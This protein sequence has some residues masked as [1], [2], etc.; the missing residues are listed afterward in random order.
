MISNND[1]FYSEV[2]RY[3]NSK[4]VSYDILLYIMNSECISLVKQLRTF[5]KYAVKKNKCYYT[6][7]I[8]LC[9]LQNNID[10]IIC[11]LEIDSNITIPAA[12]LIRIFQTINS[13]N[14]LATALQRDK[15]IFFHLMYYFPECKF[16]LQTY[17]M[18]LVDLYSYD[19]FEEIIYRGLPRDPLLYD[20]AIQYS[21]KDAIK[22]LLMNEYPYDIQSML[23]TALYY[24]LLDMIKFIF[25]KFSEHK[26]MMKPL[27]INSRLYREVLF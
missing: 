9:Q 6:K 10:R 15:R 4:Y 22:L 20:D 7:I 24:D 18:I 21:N 11:L 26:D 8:H 12:D 23:N 1:E 2:L 5:S 13:G 19:L 3:E 17:F 27:I 16:T 14:L 25:E